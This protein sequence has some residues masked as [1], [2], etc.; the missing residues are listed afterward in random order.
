MAAGFL[1]FLP[2][3]NLFAQE[4]GLI[5][6]E[7]FDYEAG[8][9]LLADAPDGGEGWNGAWTINSSNGLPGMAT[10]IDGGLG[11]MDD[12]GNILITS[13][14]HAYVDTSVEGNKNA[15][16]QRFFS[17]AIGSE[18]GTYYLSFIGERLGEPDPVDP[19][20]GESA[21]HPNNFGRNAQLA[22]LSEGGGEAAG[23]GNF[24]NN[25]TD[26]W[27]LWS[28]NGD[29]DARSGDNDS[30]VQ[31]SNNQQFAVVKVELGAGENG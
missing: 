20:T 2:F 4:N 31:F 18:G 16:F 21:Y 19:E 12:A 25:T 1:T 9:D 26:T 7:P 29:L 15:Q 28:G 13:G 24:S 5:A 6:Y 30:G 14:N 17:E 3:S 11:Y 8:T 10:V 22:I 23:I 27:R